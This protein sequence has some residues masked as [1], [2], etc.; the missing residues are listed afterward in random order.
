MRNRSVPLLLVALLIAA[1]PLACGGDEG[2]PPQRRSLGTEQAAERRGLT[3]AAAARV[4]SGNEAYRAGDYEEARR[5]FRAA[6]EEQPES[7]AVWFGVYMAERALGNEDSARA[8]LERAGDLPHPGE[9]LHP[10][11]GDTA[12]APGPES[13]SASTSG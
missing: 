9:M 13:G 12:P 4:D 10:P 8:A 11:P 2:P 1:G 6:A 3:P 5:H 7:Q